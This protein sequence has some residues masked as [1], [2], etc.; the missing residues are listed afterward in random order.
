[1]SSTAARSVGPA[2]VIAAAIFWIAFDGGSYGVIERGSHALVALWALTVGVALGLWP[3]A[4]LPG[5]ALVTGGLIVGL[6]GWIGLST[7][8]G[9][10]AE[11]S[12]AEFNRVTLYLA[13]FLI[14]VVVID[15]RRLL[16]ALGGIAVATTC[17]GLLALASRLFPSLIAETS[18]LAQLFP[19]A[20]KRL[21][22][23]VNYWNGLATLV[24]FSLP[25]LLFFATSSRNALL[26]GLA[27]LPVPALAGTIFLTSSR[28][29]TVSAVVAVLV[30]VALAVR[31]WASVAAV[32][33]TTAGAAGVVALLAAR[34][35]LVDRPLESDLAV[36]QG[37][38]AAVLIFVIC[39]ATSAVWA[40]ASHFA[41]APPRLPRW[42]QA[43]LA[44]TLVALAG[45][46]VAISDPRGRFERFK[47]VPPSLSDASVQEHLFSGSGNGR[48]QLWGVAIDEFQREPILGRGPGS[49]EAAWAE[50]GTLDLFVRDA[51]SLYLETLAEIGVVGFLLVVA[52]LLTGVAVG[53]RRA[54]AR[55]EDERSAAAAL[56]ALVVAYGFEAGFDWMWELTVVSAVAFLALGLLVGPAT[57]PDPAPAPRA[58]GL[59]MRAALVAGLIVLL[60][61]QG[62]ALLAELKIRDSREAA[63]SADYAEAADD[64][65]AA[66]ALEPWAASP[67]LQLALSQELDG[68]PQEAR[69]A[70]NEAL[71]RDR[72]DWRLWL[73]GA[74]L[75]TKVG[76]FEAARASLARAEQLNPRSQLFEEE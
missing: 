8:W 15:R 1:M 70:I 53:L 76:D 54:L 28:G 42:M 43:G 56:L 4:P 60:V 65:R 3:R 58:L 47:E 49:Y 13:A 22:Y 24:G 48:W 50:H 59:P 39:V 26:R 73:V 23:P 75:Q 40:L 10:S 51:H 25:L 44:V 67:Y 9:E 52:T 71:E 17:V 68:R 2:L 27:V 74:R 29:G 46:G 41:P 14:A 72:S 62:V 37:R 38:S 61:V 69:D 34:P 20:E 16:P 57:R 19:A 12:V 55:R 11:R 64:A 36:S 32:A 33:L 5:A 21:S 18:G 66:T 7:L 6:A 45:A 30:Y 63:A 31:R 35:E